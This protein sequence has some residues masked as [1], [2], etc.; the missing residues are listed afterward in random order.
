MSAV[1]P[2][3]EGWVGIRGR[4]MT[5]EYS[6]AV[7][8]APGLASYAWCLKTTHQFDHRWRGEK[9]Q[10]ALYVIGWSVDGSHGT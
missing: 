1:V 3:C 7:G 2:E 8:V 9:R 10:L 6:R 5:W 4:D